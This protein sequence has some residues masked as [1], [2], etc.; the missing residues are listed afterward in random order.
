MAIG[1]QGEREKCRHKGNPRK[2]PVSGP[3]RRQ[4]NPAD[5]DPGHRP[6]RQR[7]EPGSGSAARLP[8]S[9]G[10]FKSASPQSG[11]PFMKR[12]VA[13]TL[14]PVLAVT[15]CIQP[16]VEPVLEPLPPVTGEGAVAPPRV[17]GSVGTLTANTPVLTSTA[18]P[19]TLPLRLAGDTTNLGPITLDFANSD[20][21]EVS[22]QILGDILHVNYTIDPAVHGTATLH[23]TTPMTRGQLVGLLHRC[24]PPTTRPWWRAPAFIGWC[25]PPRRQDRWAAATM[26]RYRCATRRRPNS[27]RSCSRSCRPEARWPPIPT[28]TR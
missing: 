27:P 8:R 10:Q 28:A 16:P 17:N 26:Q 22:S 13:L 20:I 12:C 25:R 14:V 1:G 2:T 15:G 6:Q 23:T 4:P 5:Q 9:H 21:R 19:A 11:R 3:P 7:L 24:L 18:A